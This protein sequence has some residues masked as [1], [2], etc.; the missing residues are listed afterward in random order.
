MKA[1]TKELHKSNMPKSVTGRYIEGVGMRK[2]AVARVR[3][4]EAK[5]QDFLINGRKLE[6]YFVLP[7][8]QLTVKEA[9]NKAE[10]STPFFVSVMVKGSG[11]SAQAEAIRH[12]IARALVE[13]DPELRPTLK[14]AGFLK[15]DPRQVE[16]KKFGLRKA[17]KKEQWSKR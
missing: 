3:I 17:R 2:T 1:E 11:V 12:G 8:D 9:L 5:T 7:A 13:Y 16:R 10:T 15:R 4:F 6:E 14:K